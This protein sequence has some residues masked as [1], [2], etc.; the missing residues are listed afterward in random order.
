MTPVPASLRARKIPGEPEIW[1]FVAGDLIV[2]SVFFALIALGQ[3]QSTDMFAQSRA[4]LDLRTGLVNTLLLLTASWFV[5][6]AVEHHREGAR[7][8]CTRHFTFAM[9]CGAGF[10][11]NKAMEWGTKLQHGITPATNEFFMLF[12]VFTGIHLLDVLV[13]IAV[14]GILRGVSRRSVRGPHD[15]RTLESGATFWHLVD[16]LWIVLFALLYLL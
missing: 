7:T 2:F 13:G 5:A 8:S 9:L 1:L 15:L 11:A 4:Q 14:L 16:L 6:K 3:R 12:F 10:V